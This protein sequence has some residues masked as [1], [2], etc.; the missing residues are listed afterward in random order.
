ML[1]FRV[2]LQS[3]L[4]LRRSAIWSSILSKSESTLEV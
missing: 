1:W 3:E 2:G 4:G